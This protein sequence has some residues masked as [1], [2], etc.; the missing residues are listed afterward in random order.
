MSFLTLPKDVLEY[1]CSLDR[2][3]Y[4]PIVILCKK[5]KELLQEYK[6]RI[7]S[8]CLPKYGELHSCIREFMYNIIEGKENTHNIY[9]LQIG[10]FDS[11]LTRIKTYSCNKIKW[12]KRKYMPL[13]IS[14]VYCDP[15]MN[16]IKVGSA[17]FSIH[18]KKLTV[19]GKRITCI[20][21]DVNTRID[22]VLIGIGECINIF[23]PTFLPDIH[24]LTKIISKRG[25]SLTDEEST[26]LAKTIIADNIHKIGK[27][28]A[29]VEKLKCFIET[30]TPITPLRTQ[31]D[32]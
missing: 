29:A 28:K 14:S 5:T 6:K 21:V 11:I 30:P 7:Y 15:P 17:E 32:S 24:T 26:N 23:K 9:F 31:P 19:N 13:T 25:L 4:I 1:I 12:K 3:N 10:Y 20:R 22:N 27:D 8:N 2:E 16:T 18:F